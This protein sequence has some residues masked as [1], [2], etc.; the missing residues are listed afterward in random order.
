MVAMLVNGGYV[1][2]PWHGTVV[3]VGVARG[4]QQLGAACSTA[5]GTVHGM[6]ECRK[7][8][9]FSVLATTHRQSTATTARRLP[10][11]YNEYFS[12]MTG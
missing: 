11:T 4:V 8:S 3:V 5:Y 9:G 2:A 1:G 6:C 7:R 10:D 12:F